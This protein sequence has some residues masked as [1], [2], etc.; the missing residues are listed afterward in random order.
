M[1]KILLLIVYLSSF[2][3]SIVFAQ[4]DPF[5]RVEIETKSDDA[6]FKLIPCGKQGL[7][8]FYETTVKEDN[9]KFWVFVLYNKF[10]Q[11]NWKKDI[12]V[13]DTYLTSYMHKT[14][15]ICTFSFMMR[16]RRNPKHITIRL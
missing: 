3:T 13:F 7:V 15:T 12:P 8:F 2:T 16:K 4:S 5:L 14:A 10:M 9:Y 11:E 1:K 6:A